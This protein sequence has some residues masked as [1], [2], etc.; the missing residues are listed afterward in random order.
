MQHIEPYE[1]KVQYYE[2]DK[3]GITHHSNYVRW[4]EEA[5]V[6]FLSKIGWDFDKLEASGVASPVISIDVK[7]KGSTV[8][9]EVI[10]ITVSILALK[11]VRLTLGYEMKNA[12]GKVVCEAQSEHCFLNTEG[13][14]IRLEKDCPEF[15]SALS[16]LIR[17]E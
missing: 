5:R 16:E 6:D 9:P 8:F 10:T 2:T 17:S 1:H 7:Y 11:S 14:P 4:M 15:Y 13:R 3:M 12:S